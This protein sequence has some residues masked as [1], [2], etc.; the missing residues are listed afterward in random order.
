MKGRKITGKILLHIAIANA[1]ED[2]QIIFF[3]MSQNASSKKKIIAASKCREAVNSMITRGFKAYINVYLVGMLNLLSKS[4]MMKI[5]HTSIININA[6][7][8][9]VMV[10][11]LSPVRLASQKKN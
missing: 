3:W 1:S 7:M 4:L 8:L 2:N 6:F 5:E 11:T 10:V 9:M